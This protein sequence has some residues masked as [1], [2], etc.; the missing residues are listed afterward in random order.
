MYLDDLVVYSDSWSSHMQRV[1]A[2]CDR[3]A[4]AKLTVNLPKREFARASGR[5][6]GQ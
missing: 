1:R 2:L 6:V 4:E 5:M 3:L